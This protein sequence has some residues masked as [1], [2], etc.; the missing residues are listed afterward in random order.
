MAT[1]KT[2]STKVTK[3]V[4][5]STQAIVVTGAPQEA[6]FATLMEMLEQLEKTQKELTALGKK[7]SS[8]EA[9]VYDFDSNT[10]EIKN[11][12]EVSK[13]EEAMGFVVNRAEAKRK[14]QEA[15]GRPVTEFKWNGHTVEEWKKTINYRIEVVASEAKL[16][17]V[18]AMIKRIKEIPAINAATAFVDLKK[19]YAKL[20]KLG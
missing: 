12:K 8:I 14:G 5:P 15:L 6:D 7:A 13:L 2:K 10:L 1:R 4:T 3:K 20:V 11:E 9:E 18:S 17:A 16:K 19:E